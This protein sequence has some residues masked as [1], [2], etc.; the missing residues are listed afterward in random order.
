MVETV[1]K[2]AG[3]YHNNLGGNKA[4]S[5]DG[6][7]I[8]YALLF[9]SP[10]TA[11]W[12]I[13]VLIAAILTG[14]TTEFLAAFLL[15]TSARYGMTSAVGIWPVLALSGSGSAFVLLLFNMM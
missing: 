9:I 5:L 2:F 13:R 15:V 7:T 14:H 4:I 6:A 10:F 8:K 12:L 1:A 3:S 11:F